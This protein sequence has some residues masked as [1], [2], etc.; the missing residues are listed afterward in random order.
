M[1]KLPKEFKKRRNKFGDVPIDKTDMIFYLGIEDEA[2]ISVFLAYD[3]VVVSEK[4]VGKTD[5][6]GFRC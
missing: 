2:K 3:K 5:E 1:D 4:R 6:K